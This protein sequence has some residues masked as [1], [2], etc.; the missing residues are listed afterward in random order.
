M[1]EIS[2]SLSSS[3]ANA[4]IHQKNANLYESRSPW[5]ETATSGPGSGE[6]F[7]S[8]RASRVG[9][10]RRRG[11]TITTHGQPHH[12]FFWCMCPLLVTISHQLR[13]GI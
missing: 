10:N 4:L 7:R 6:T 12:L 8:S 3:Y 5:I 9:V 1:I 13:S 2:S 11:S